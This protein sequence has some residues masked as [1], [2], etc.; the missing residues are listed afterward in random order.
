MLSTPVSGTLG[1]KGGARRSPVKPVDE[2]IL[3]TI[4]SDHKDMIVS[5]GI[6]DHISRPQ[7]PVGPGLAKCAPLLK[8]LLMAAPAAE[9]PV[10]ASRNAFQRV[11]LSNPGL[12]D[13]VFNMNTYAGQ[14][15]DRICV[16][17]NHVR[18]LAGDKTGKALQACGTKMRG[19]RP[20]SFEDA[21]GHG[22]DRGWRNMSQRC[23]DSLRA[24]K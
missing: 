9:L 23:G 22:R 8:R 10:T 2:G 6:Y 11:L 14:R 1:S 19:I 4:F 5:L 15:V 24:S 13:S 17:M 3:M 7:S 16:M 20:S 12:N 18:R 21:V